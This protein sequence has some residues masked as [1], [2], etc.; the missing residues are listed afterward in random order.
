M[1]ISELTPYLNCYKT[2]L[3]NG[4]DIALRMYIWAK[5]NFRVCVAYTSMYL[6]QCGDCTALASF[7]FASADGSC[8]GGF[9]VEC[10]TNQPTLKV[11]KIKRQQFLFL[12]LI[13]FF[14]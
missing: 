6:L 4:R 10:N 8:T 11:K 14:V 7:V 13:P 1:F 9:G 3:P 5:S 12:S 2:L